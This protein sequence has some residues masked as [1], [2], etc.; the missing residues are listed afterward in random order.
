MKQIIIEQINREEFVDLLHEAVTD[1]ND[2]VRNEQ[3]E[4]E[5]FT[6]KEVQDMFKSSYGFVSSLI[7]KGYL[8]TTAD[9]K[10]SGKAI[11]EYYRIKELLK[12]KDEFNRIKKLLESK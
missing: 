10:I 9:G 2:K 7:G 4:R 11:N 1:A 5:I 8:H 3:F 6:K 12:K